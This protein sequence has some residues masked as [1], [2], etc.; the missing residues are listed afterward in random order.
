MRAKAASLN[1]L[2]ALPG[3]AQF[4]QQESSPLP[5][6]SVSSRRNYQVDR[7]GAFALLVRFDLERNAL[8]FNQIL[9]SVPSTQ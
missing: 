4:S 8:P 1:A 5:I 3:P 9:Q 2:G 7:L 6:A